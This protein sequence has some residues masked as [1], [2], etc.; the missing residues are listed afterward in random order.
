MGVVMIFYTTTFSLIEYE[1]ENCVE[2]AL[3]LL[4]SNGYINDELAIINECGDKCAKIEIVDDLTIQFK[5]Y[6]RNL[7]NIMDSVSKGYKK[8]YIVSAST[9]G[10]YRG[11]VTVDG[12]TTVYELD[13][14]E[15]KIISESP[16][17]LS[18][19]VSKYKRKKVQL[20]NE[21]VDIFTQ[22]KSSILISFYA[23]FFL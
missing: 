5:S 6:F 12:N 15:K 8:R 22:E 13:E 19:P 14:Y 10:L 23:Y 3:N 9:D 20:Q 17:L 7:F 21:I 18:L 16:I 2:E 1:S 11:W 4:K